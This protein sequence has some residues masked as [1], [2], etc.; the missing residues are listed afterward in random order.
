MKK[1]LSI[2]LVFIMGSIFIVGCSNDPYIGRYK[3]SDNTILELSS[4]GNCTIINNLYKDVF[5]TYGKYSIND[6]EIEITF[7]NNEENYFRV[8]S[9]KGKVKGS[10]IEFYNCS[11]DGKEW[12][13]SK[14]G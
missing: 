2:F 1:M 9:L 4:N 11:V 12:I 8:Q 10:S 5:Y 14:E 6:N 3:S 13:Y 7:E